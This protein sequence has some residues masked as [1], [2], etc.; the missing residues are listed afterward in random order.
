MSVH[1]VVGHVPRSPSAFQPRDD[2]LAL[3]RAGDGETPA[4]HVITGP[5]GA[6]KTQLAAAYARKDIAAGWPLVAWVD[7]SDPFSVLAG[8]TAV[9][10]GLG[11]FDPRRGSPNR[12]CR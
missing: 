11:F 5:P 9:G 7:A 2:L 10:A 3:L 12:P 6:G 1:G 4:V 8:L